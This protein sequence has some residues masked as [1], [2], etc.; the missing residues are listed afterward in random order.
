MCIQYHDRV[1]TL[2]YYR[3][4][5]YCPVRRKWSTSWL[6]SE[7]QARQRWPDAQRIEHTRTEVQ[8]AETD[9]EAMGQATNVHSKW[10]RRQD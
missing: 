4:R 2:V 5:I 3:W 8:V 6:M 7:A 1:K 9:H 10:A